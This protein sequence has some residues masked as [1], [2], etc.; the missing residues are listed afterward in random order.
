MSKKKTKETHL[1]GA[2]C[3]KMATTGWPAFTHLCTIC[4]FGICE[5]KG[6]GG[7]GKW[8]LSSV[9]VIVLVVDTRAVVVVFVIN[10]GMV[11]IIFNINTSAVYQSAGGRSI[12]FAVAKPWQVL[13]A[14]CAV[15]GATVAL[16]QARGSKGQAWPCACCAIQ[17][18]SRAQ[19]TPPFQCFLLPMLTPAAV[20]VAAQ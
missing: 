13:K 5:G 18:Q 11:V 6:E 7:G 15:A 1:S 2:K 4:I 20:V 17:W 19:A 8:G 12:P 10:A 9:L 14:R 3:C 16:K